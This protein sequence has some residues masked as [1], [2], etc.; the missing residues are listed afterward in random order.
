MLS[1]QTFTSKIM[2]FSILILIKNSDN[3]VEQKWF[4]RKYIMYNMD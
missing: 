3:E 1:H 2:G 4:S